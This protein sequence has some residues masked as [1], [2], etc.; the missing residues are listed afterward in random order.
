V[1]NH[2]AAYD[3]AVGASRAEI[4]ALYRDRYLGFR[5]GLAA[6]T[7]SYETAH[8]V[9]QEAFARALAQGGTYR[10]D[11]PL[12][13]WVWGIAMRVAYDER[14]RPRSVPLEDSIGL[15]LVDPARDPEL[16]EALRQLP[17][18]RRMIFFLRYFADMSYQEI[19]AVCGVSQGTVA[20]SLAHAKA[21]LVASLETSPRTEEM[22]P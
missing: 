17:P 6:V 22:R 4:E 15:G 3:P 2:I 1:A 9:V 7:G 19:G 5:R 13:A 16:S 21:A 11:A 14:R 12:G 20:A 8:D 10:G 18:R